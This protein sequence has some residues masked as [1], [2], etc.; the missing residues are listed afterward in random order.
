MAWRNLDFTRGNPKAKF[1]NADKD[2]GKQN[3]HKF[4]KKDPRHV[5]FMHTCEDI[6]TKTS[7]DLRN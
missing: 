2:R 3:A 5:T 6:V 4:G 7:A 1:S